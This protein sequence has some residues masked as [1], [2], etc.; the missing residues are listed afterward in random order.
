[1]SKNAVTKISG[2][3]NRERNAAGIIAIYK[4]ISRIAVI[5]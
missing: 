5:A 4:E 3:V 2:I 1:M